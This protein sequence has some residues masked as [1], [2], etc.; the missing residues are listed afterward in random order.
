MSQ[1][2]YKQAYELASYFHDLDKEQSSTRADDLTLDEIEDRYGSMSDWWLI[3]LSW[4]AKERAFWARMS[5]LEVDNCLAELDELI[6]D[7]RLIFN[8]F[9]SAY[10]IWDN[11]YSEIQPLLI[12][13]TNLL[14]YRYRVR[15][16][17]I[18]NE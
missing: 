7:S 16:G 15:D 13:H 10:G 6:E 14:D 17:E 11:V 3:A 5:R 9:G 8:G 18:I 4:E 1:L 2:T 12:R